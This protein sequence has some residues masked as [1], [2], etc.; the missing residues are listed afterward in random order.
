MTLAADRLLRALVW[1]AIDFRDAGDVEG[2][3]AAVAELVHIMWTL[4]P[5]VEYRQALIDAERDLEEILART[6]AEPWL[7]HDLWPFP[8]GPE[9][10]P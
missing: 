9:D 4:F 2:F 6:E 10:T 8:F 7:V 1:R 5:L 3:R